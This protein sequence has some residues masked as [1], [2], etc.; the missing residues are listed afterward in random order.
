[1]NANRKVVLKNDILSALKEIGVSK[2]QSIMVHTSLSS[3]GFVCGGPQIVIEALLES[4]GEEGTIMMP[5][6]SWKNLDPSTGVH[7]EEPEE[8]HDIIRENWP[9]YDKDITPT[10]TMGAVAEMF[11]KWKGTFRSDHPARSVAA[12][13]KYAKHLTENHDLSNIFGEGSPLSKLYDLDGY[14]LLIGVGYDKNTSLHLADVRGNYPSKHN[15]IEHS[16]IMENGKRVWKAYETLFVDGEDFDQI[17][18]AFEKSCK[19]TKVP[20]GN[21]TLTFMKQRELVDF[22]VKWIEE[23]RK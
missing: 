2:G 7:W 21:A 20:L 19:V 14:V 9:A 18:S 17:G 13:G 10:N 12:W 11:R 8:W 22:A 4:I 5:T 23:N 15:C 1:M 3:L 16:A 6:Q